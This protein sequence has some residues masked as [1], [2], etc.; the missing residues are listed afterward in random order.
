MNFFNDHK[1]RF[2]GRSYKQSFEKWYFTTDTNLIFLFCSEFSFIILRL[3]SHYG[4]HIPRSALRSINIITPIWLAGRTCPSSLSTVTL[5]SHTSTHSEV[6]LA[7]EGKQL[8]CSQMELFSFVTESCLTLDAWV[9]PLVS[10]MSPCHSTS[11]LPLPLWPGLTSPQPVCS[12][13]SHHRWAPLQGNTAPGGGA[14]YCYYLAG[15]GLPNTM[16]EPLCSGDDG[17]LVPSLPQEQAMEHHCSISMVS[18]DNYE[19]LSIAVHPWELEVEKPALW[20]ATGSGSEI[21]ALKTVLLF[22]LA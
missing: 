4:M 12:T 22:A 21:R 7:P 2:I 3:M 8:N 10:A 1:E 5:H 11:W 17:C 20:A 9:P 14:S 16:V 6:S 13:P 18:K 15:K 19:R